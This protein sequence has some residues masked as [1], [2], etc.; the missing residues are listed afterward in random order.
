MGWLILI[1]FIIIVVIV[2]IA[3]IQN[4][5]KYRPDFDIDSHQEA[6]GEDES[7]GSIKSELIL[8]S[9]EVK[10]EIIPEVIESTIPIKPDDLTVIEGIGPKVK[11]LLNSAGILSYADLAKADPE[12]LRSLLQK[13][14]LQFLDPGTWPEQARLAS[15]SRFSDLKD[16]Q[17][18]LKAGRG[19][20]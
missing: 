8:P 4:A 19:E 13:E 6:H 3:L 10:D 9:P 14:R 7:S 11:K 2:W 16:L 20:K 1:L 12:Q 18:Q 15:E 5:R 17:A